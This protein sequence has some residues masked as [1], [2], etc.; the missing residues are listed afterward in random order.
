MDVYLMEE[1][2]TRNGENCTEFRMLLRAIGQ[3]GADRK[4]PGPIT[5]EEIEALR[6]TGKLLERATPGE[7]LRK[8]A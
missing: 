4:K 6:R 5:T 3:L 1:N 2:V 8:S 7:V